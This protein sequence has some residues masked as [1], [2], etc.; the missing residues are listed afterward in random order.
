MHV[1]DGSGGGGRPLLLRPER[2]SNEAAVIE[3]ETG[4]SALLTVSAT[5]RLIES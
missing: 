2:G 4:C 5:P 3:L 1:E